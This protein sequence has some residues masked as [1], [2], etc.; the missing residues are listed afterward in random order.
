MSIRGRVNLLDGVSQRATTTASAS[1]ETTHCKKQ[2][3]ARLQSENGDPVV[4][5]FELSPDV[6]T[7]SLPQLS[8]DFRPK[9]SQQRPLSL[10]IALTY[11]LKKLSAHLEYQ[12]DLP[13]IGQK[14]GVLGRLSTCL[15]TELQGDQQH[16]PYTPVVHK[17][18]ACILTVKVASL[19]TSNEDNN[20]IRCLANIWSSTTDKAQAQTI[21]P[22][23]WG[24]GEVGGVNA[25]S[26]NVSDATTDILF[27]GIYRFS[28]HERNEL[29]GLG[30]FSICS[31]QLNQSFEQ[32]VRLFC[33]SKGKET[34]CGSVVLG[35]QTA[36]VPDET[37]S[38]RS[39]SL[40]ATELGSVAYPVQNGEMKCGFDID[41]LEVHELPAT[42]SEGD[43]ISI[44]LRIAQS[45]WK[46][47]LGPTKVVLSAG[48][49][50]L[51][52]S[53]VGKAYAKICWSAK[54][55]SFPVLEVLVYTESQRTP[56]LKSI[57][58]KAS[59]A[60]T[61]HLKR[62]GDRRGAKATQRADEAASPVLVAAGSLNLCSFFS[63]PNTS[64]RVDLSLT[65]EK[66]D[67]ET[68][69]CEGPV[70]ILSTIRASSYREE[71]ASAPTLPETNVRQVQVIKGDLCI[72]L[73]QATGSF[74]RKVNP[75]S[76][77]YVL[78]SCG[79][80]EV[81][82]GYVTFITYLYLTVVIVSLK[83]TVACL[84]R[85][86]SADD[87]SVTW[88]QHVVLRIGSNGPP[89]VHLTLYHRLV[90][91]NGGDSNPA[92]PIEGNQIVGYLTLPMFPSVLEEDHLLQ[93]EVPF[94]MPFG[95]G[96]VDS[97]KTSNDPHYYKRGMLTLE[98][99]FLSSEQPK[100]KASTTTESF[101]LVIH[102]V[103]GNLQ[104]S[105]PPNAHLGSY[106]MSSL[107]LVSCRIEVAELR[108]SRWELP[109]LY[110][111][112]RQE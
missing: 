73:L 66:A 81:A 60:T 42:V 96:D 88:N 35:L 6:V 59:L 107:I 83:Y 3:C 101:E 82:S 21:S 108:R 48:G 11:L 79:S 97:A 57:A 71:G 86:C 52:A 51:M 34:E 99:Q 15:R 84:C 103:R 89:T 94:G 8:L 7:N 1:L 14:G 2:T 76:S 54:D 44:Q 17:P 29:I 90:D 112:L 43:S 62:R 111:Y 26:L 33:D 45:N 30:I 109:A 74:L 27:V 19:R 55:R 53:I 58:S 77:Y 4:L 49:N 22:L 5:R 69:N 38:E 65:V 9:R 12:C 68:V 80:E 61:S 20:G 110:Q 23:T 39:L 50:K 106:S 102:R 92:P 85:F 10:S 24:S 46:I 91:R 16:I 98:M 63:Q 78:V 47:K 95:S 40:A 31:H 100:V 41:I 64:A 87:G 70:S 75:L 105:S 67:M 28:N 37:E 36:S 18:Q 32:S 13:L 72:H 56:N 25:V 104:D 93:L